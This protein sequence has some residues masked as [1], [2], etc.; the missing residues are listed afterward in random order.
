MKTS[1]KTRVLGWF[2]SNPGTILAMVNAAQREDFACETDYVTFA[3]KAHSTAMALVRE[4]RMVRELKPAR[5]A[6]GDTVDQWHYSVPRTPVAVVAVTRQDTEV[7]R[8]KAAL[9]ALEA[10]NA[11]LYELLEE[12]TAPKQEAV[13]A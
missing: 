11:A 13:A 5:D 3:Q 6:K 10:D 4:G 9:A 7:A 2:S 12:A 1:K 8:L